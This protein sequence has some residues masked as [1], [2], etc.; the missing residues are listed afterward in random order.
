VPEQARPKSMSP[1]RLFL[2]RLGKMRMPF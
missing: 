2:R 1:F